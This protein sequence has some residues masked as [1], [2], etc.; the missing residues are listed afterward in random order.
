MSRR[1]ASFFRPTLSWSGAFLTRWLWSGS[2]H[3]LKNGT[4]KDGPDFS[5]SLQDPRVSH[6]RYLHNLHW[7]RLR[8]Q[9]QKQTKTRVYENINKNNNKKLWKHQQ[10]HQQQQDTVM[11][12]STTTGNINS[13][14]WE[15]HERVM[16]KQ[17]KLII[18][19]QQQQPYFIS[20][21][22]HKIPFFKRGSKL[23]KDRRDPTVLACSRSTW[24]T[25]RRTICPRLTHA[26]T[27][28]TS[29]LTSPL[30]SSRKNSPVP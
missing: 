27:A 24:S 3:W 21:Y 25:L 30:I 6:C 26:S 10:Q 8:K 28:S 1:I 5:N 19:T 2:G 9:Q 11:I 14:S 16:R 29:R 4:T 15:N 22:A 23:C 13:K 7:K 12:K 18:C 17:R 20:N